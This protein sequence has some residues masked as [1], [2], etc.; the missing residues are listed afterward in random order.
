[1]IH[2]SVV[3]INHLVIGFPALKM[4]SAH[5]ILSII[6]I[7]LH[8]LLSPTYGYIKN[9]AGLTTFPTDIP[10]THTYIFLL[11]NKITTIPDDAFTNF[12]LLRQIQISGNGLLHFPNLQPV[13]ST[14]QLI[15]FTVNR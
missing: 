13:A 11:K 14:L 10:F 15:D 9:N 3:N 6:P 7:L 5:G 12:T 1:M 4:S 2:I 8:F